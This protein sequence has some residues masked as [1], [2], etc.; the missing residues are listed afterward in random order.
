MV[1]SQDRLEAASIFM[2][3]MS[4]MAAFACDLVIAHYKEPM[5]WMKTFESFPFRTI[6]IYTKGDGS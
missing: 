3:H 4:K 1:G 2:L 5:E 6:F